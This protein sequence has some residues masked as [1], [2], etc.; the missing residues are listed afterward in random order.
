[1][2]KERIKSAVLLFLVLANLT[3]AYKIL[4]N[5]KLWLPGYNFFVTSKKQKNTFS[6][7]ENLALPEKI[8]V[9]TGYQSSRFDYKRSDSYFSLINEA[10]SEILKNAFSMPSKNIS[11]IPPEEWYSVLTAKSVYLAYPCS[12][13][14]QIFSEILGL[15]QTEAGFESFSDIVIGDNGNVYISSRE[16]FFRINITS[17]KIS[18]IIQTVFDGHTDEQSVINYSFDLNF[19]KDFGDQKTFLSPM[20]VIYSDPIDAPT[21]SSVNPVVKTD[22]SIANRV[23]EAILPCFSINPNTVRRYT[24]ADG[25]LV[26]VENNGILRISP[27]G[28]LTYTATGSGIKL[29]NTSDTFTGVSG[30]AAFVDKL[31][32]AAGISSEM[33]VTSPL[34]QDFTGTV[35]LDYISSGFMV[36]YP[37]SH[38]VSASVSNGYITNYSQ[39]LRI[40]T[41]TGSSEQSPLYIE[42]LD[43]VIAKYQDSM[44]TI[45]ITDMYPAYI[46][47]STNEHQSLDWYIEIDNNIAE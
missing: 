25:S 11:S 19:D 44:S 31:N 10:A 26:F 22:G 7:A 4:V 40:L 42:A 32:A 30:I 35:T 47:D 46:D 2:R 34:T 38:A 1:M 45:N 5:K 23:I 24:E 39:I 27:D 6:L 20:I 17:E 33:C 36:K 16:G 3:M 43:N 12:Y 9:N 21:L 15:S 8:I 28:I 13:T 18:P 41:P 14:A 37:Q 29:V